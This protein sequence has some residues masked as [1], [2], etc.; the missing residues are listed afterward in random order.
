V[1]FGGRCVHSSHFKFNLITSFIPFVSEGCRAL[2][3]EMLLCFILE[4]IVRKLARAVKHIFAA[5]WLMHDLLFLCRV[6]D[7]LLA[8]KVPIIIGLMLKF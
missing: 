4:G 1:V 6:G 3:G 8:V 7:D 2:L 5:V